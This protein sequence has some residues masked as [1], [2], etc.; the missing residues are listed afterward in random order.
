MKSLILFLTSLIFQVSGQTPVIV[1]TTSGRL[2]G[3]ELN[4]V[5]SFKGV[6]FAQAPTGQRRW[7]PPVPFVSIAAQNATVLAPSCIQQ[8]SFATSAFT[9]FVFNN[10]P[11][12]SENEDCLF[13][14]VWAPATKTNE[15]KPVVV[16]IY[17]GLVYVVLK[18]VGINNDVHRGLMFG[19]ASL[20]GYD[21]TSL[22]ADQDLVVVTFNYRTN[23][24]GF[25]SSG[26]LPIIQNNLGFLDQE[27]AL[28][29]VQL[30][31]AQFGGDP[32]KVTIMGQSAGA[33]SVGEA[34]VRDRVKTPFRAG[35]MLSGAPFSSSPIPSFAPFNTFATA[36]GCSQTPGPARLNC[37]K[38]VPAATIRN[39]TNGPLSGTFVPVVD[40]ITAFANPIERLRAGNSAR[41]P[42]VLG[43]TENDGTVFTLGVTNLTSF[44]G[45]EIPIPGITIPPD[46]VRSLYTGQNDSIVIAD[47]FRDLA[48]R[49]PDELW[50]AAVT[51]AG[52]S[53]FRYSYGR[54]LKDVQGAVFA[55][56][57][58][59]PGAGAWHSS[60][61]GPLFG[62][63]IRAT[64]TP[65]EVAWSTT[66]QTA[67]ANFVKNPNTSP[68]LNWPKY[69]P[70]P[71]TFRVI[72]WKFPILSPLKECTAAQLVICKLNTMNPA[73]KPT[74]QTHIIP[75]SPFVLLCLIVL[76]SV[77]FTGMLSVSGQPP[78]PRLRTRAR[79]LGVRLAC[80][81]KRENSHE[82]ERVGREAGDSMQGI[83]EKR[84]MGR[85]MRWNRRFIRSGLLSYSERP[86]QRPVCGKCE[87]VPKNDPC[88]FLDSTPRFGVGP[89]DDGSPSGP[90]G[91]PFLAGAAEAR[92]Y[93]SPDVE[94]SSPASLFSDLSLGSDTHSQSETVSDN[95][96][97]DLDIQEPP[98]ETIMMSWDQSDQS[99]RYWV[100]K[101]NGDRISA[102]KVVHHSPYRLNR[103]GAGDRAVDNGIVKAINNERK[104]LL[105]IK[106][107]SLRTSGANSGNQ[108]RI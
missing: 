97:V 17:G 30:N 47:T 18:M 69:V 57:Q 63:F 9:Q 21:G 68:A 3:A 94:F 71:S 101:G 32:N 10:P 51:S 34:I 1:S 13:L 26:D 4:G 54:S 29:W 105:Q 93:G 108:F 81:W 89:N 6:R 95:S 74:E 98:S 58:K 19:T 65:A 73:F 28:Q 72:R 67:I 76:V 46:L 12:A 61:L 80:V 7:E 70:G 88:Q 64:A 36:V 23:I 27:L 25:P 60:E 43:T 79:R 106:G 104:K 44:L 38:A 90:S 83:G 86:P 59:F 103:T 49:C 16:W 20:P 5:V 62:T 42:I 41:V 11:P 102:V 53:V 91:S 107:M 84:M 8:F 50:G 37:L 2:E 56:L 14:N 45:A 48:F 35:I 77:P 15:K 31:I 82:G 99:H 39:F 85:E 87:R 40:N 33:Q 100:A 24:F 78:H 75:T 92:G 66:F 52:E 55:D 22:A 96:F